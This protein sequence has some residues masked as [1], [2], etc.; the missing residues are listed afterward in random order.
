MRRFSSKLKYVLNNPLV[1]WWYIQGHILWFIH[2]RMIIKWYK[3]SIE[4]P[5]CFEAGTCI[6]CGCPFNEKSLSNKPCGIKQN[7]TLVK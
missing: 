1:I 3:K 4:C 6:Q 7:L 5:E 2:G